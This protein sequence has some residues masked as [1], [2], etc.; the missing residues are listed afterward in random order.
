[1]IKHQR[2]SLQLS[3]NFDELAKNAALVMPD[4]IRHP[5]LIEM[6]GFRPAPE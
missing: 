5:E 2:R 3:L 1:M 4:L 6:P